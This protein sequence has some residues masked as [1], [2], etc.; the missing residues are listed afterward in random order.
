MEASKQVVSDYD[1]CGNYGFDATLRID[2][3]DCRLP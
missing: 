3:D 1:H 2:L